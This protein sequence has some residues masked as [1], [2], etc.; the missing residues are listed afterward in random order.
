MKTI[1]I[2]A[3]AA[4]CRGFVADI[5]INPVLIGVILG[6]LFIGVIIYH[7]VDQRKRNRKMQESWDKLAEPQITEYHV[8]VADMICDA[9]S[10]GYAQPTLEKSF[11]VAFLT[12]NGEKLELEVN[13][14]I[15]ISLNVGDSGMLAILNEKFY[16]FVPD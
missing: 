3:G 5:E 11:H 1:I 8:T 10:Y 2:T 4:Q 13:E 12:D 7:I 9:E 6:A 16:G 14:S 15:Y